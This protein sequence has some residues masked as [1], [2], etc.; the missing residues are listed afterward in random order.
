MNSSESIKNL[1]EAFTIAQDQM[2]GAEKGASNPFFKSSY[3]DLNSVINAVKAP[4]NRNGLSFIQHPVSTERSIGVCTRIMHVSGEWIE[5]EF[6][7]PLT[8]AD[9][10]A[11]ASLIT[12]ARRYGLQS[13]CG[14]PAVDD[15]GNAASGR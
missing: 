1:S 14:I 15:D 7:L 12:Y 3:A 13:I 10:Q 6:Y 4:L 9:P 11:A 8:K 2:T 5:Q